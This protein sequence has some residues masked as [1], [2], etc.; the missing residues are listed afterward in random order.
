MTEPITPERIYQTLI[1]D[2][3]EPWGGCDRREEVERLWKLYIEQAAEV[4]RLR[5]QVTAVKRVAARHD[6]SRGACVC[7]LCAALRDVHAWSDHPTVSELATGDE[8]ERLRAQVAAVEEAW[9]SNYV[10]ENGTITWRLIEAMRAAL[11]LTDGA[12]HD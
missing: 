11:E 9:L 1:D 8:E 6:R 10:E 12:E 3:G 2:P 5:A 7:S 4:E